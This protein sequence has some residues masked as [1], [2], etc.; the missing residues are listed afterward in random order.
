[1]TQMTNRLLSVCMCVCV[2]ACAMEGRLCLSACL[3]VCVYVCVYVRVCVHLRKKAAWQTDDGLLF[4]DLDLRDGSCWCGGVVE[5]AFLGRSFLCG[6]WLDQRWGP[7]WCPQ[8]WSAICLRVCV[9]VC[10]TRRRNLFVVIRCCC[11]CY[12]ASIC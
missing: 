4:Y 2:C 5:T 9:C 3:Q 6:S 1:M 10:G 7:R 8:L 12:W 11:C